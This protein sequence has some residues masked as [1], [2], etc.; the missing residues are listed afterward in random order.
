MLLIAPPGFSNAII[1]AYRSG[2]APRDRVFLVLGERQESGGVYYIMRV[3]LDVESAGERVPAQH[4]VYVLNTQRLG[5]L[6]MIH[7]HGWSNGCE[8]LSGT[9][10]NTLRI[11]GDRFIAFVAAPNCLKAWRLVNGQ[12][13]EV[14][15]IEPKIAEPVYIKVNPR[16]GSEEEL[17]IEAP[18][19]AEQ[20]ARSLVVQKIDELIQQAVDKFRYNS[21]WAYIDYCWTLLYSLAEIRK[22]IEKTCGRKERRIF[23]SR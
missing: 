5:L 14:P 22:L 18:A 8:F 12:I 3:V 23:R 13:Q 4:I 10:I 6:G 11:L 2:A 20:Q 21:C 19:C 7:Y 17:E 1:N 16:A 15:I 9:D